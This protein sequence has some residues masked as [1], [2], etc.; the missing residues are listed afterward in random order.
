MLPLFAWLYFY[1]IFVILAYSFIKLSIGVFLLRL[2]HQTKY[3][4]A[5]RGILS[6]YSPELLVH[7]RTLALT[8]A[9]VF[10]VLFT[11]GSVLAIILQ[12]NPVAAGYDLTLRP[13]TGTGTCYSIDIFKKIGVFNSCELSPFN[14]D[15]R[16]SV[17]D[18]YSHK[19]CDRPIVRDL[20]NS[21]GLETTAQ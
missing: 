4:W 1:S 21:T 19:Y 18:Q 2:T 3:T 13:P 7:K 11:I 8:R 20:T 5:L 15:I 12:C 10:L 9:T 17:P 6:I 16:L 14:R